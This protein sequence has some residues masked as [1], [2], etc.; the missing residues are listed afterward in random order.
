MGYYVEFGQYENPKRLYILTNADIGATTFTPT[1]ITGS[2]EMAVINID[3]GEDDPFTP[4]IKQSLEVKLIRTNDNDFYDI[5]EG[6]DENTYC[7]VVDN[8][9]ISKSGTDFVLSAGAKLDFIGNLTMETY[10]EA[11]RDTAEVNLTFHDRFGVLD[12]SDFLPKKTRLTIPELLAELLPS[13]ITSTYC[14]IEWPYSTATY[15]SPDEFAL[16][17]SSFIGEKKTDVLEQFMNDFGLQALSDFT[18]IFSASATPNIFDCGCVRIRS[19]VDHVNE[20]SNYYLFKLIETV[21]G[22][23]T[24]YSYELQTTTIDITTFEIKSQFFITILSGIYDVKVDLTISGVA[25]ELKFTDQSIP[26]ENE[27]AANELWFQL[28]NTGSLIA[29]MEA[30]YTMIAH[31]P[32]L[33]DY[34]NQS[35]DSIISFQSLVGSSDYD[36]IISPADYKVWTFYYDY[37]NGTTPVVSG[38]FTETKTRYLLNSLEYPLINYDAGWELQRKAKRI[39]A[40]HE[41]ELM[42]NLIYNGEIDKQYAKDNDS[43]EV[44]TVTYEDVYPYFNVIKSGLTGGEIGLAINKFIDKVLS[45]DNIGYAPLGLYNREASIVIPEASATEAYSVM[46]TPFYLYD[47]NITLTVELIVAGEAGANIIITPYIQLANTPFYTTIN[48][49]FSNFELVGGDFETFTDT[50]TFS[51]ARLAL[52]NYQVNTVIS[53]EAGKTF[54]VKS[55]KIT[56]DLPELY[57]ENITL[58]TNI[59]TLN[60]KDKEIRTKFG[61]TPNIES[62]PFIYRNLIF[63]AAGVPIETILYK[64]LDQTLLAH[65]SDQYGVNFNYDRWLFSATVKANNLRIFNLFEIDSRVLMC[66]SGTYDL[67]KGILTGKFPEVYYSGYADVWLWDDDEELLWDDNDNIL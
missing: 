47:D 66:T 5:I 49:D 36:I 55:L 20:T 52:L 46:A 63:D 2:T 11:Y 18:T 62:S 10:G 37:F 27:W 31:I 59:N 39:K 35:T 48:P 54:Y 56:I 14:V 8:G 53:G 26:P 60:R 64:G 44:S 17:I 33:V 23:N 21:S 7:L 28:S 29:Y 51:D 9:T 30:S 24:Y 4:I 61:N 42:E 40:V 25:Y 32:E 13:V 43:F 38:I 67:H 19:V 3:S 15:D 45:D 16:D 57:P 12:D 1:E 22:V 50:W 41:L 58:Y 65:L 6:N 34:S